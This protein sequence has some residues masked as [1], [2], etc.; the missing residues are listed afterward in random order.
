MSGG[1]LYI[2]SAEDTAWKICSTAGK[3]AGNYL[4]HESKCGVTY[5][6]E[7]TAYEDRT[8]HVQKMAPNTLMGYLVYILN[9]DLFEKERT[10]KNRQER[11]QQL[12][13]ISNIMA[14]QSR[15]YR[16][17]LRKRGSIEDYSQKR[18]RYNQQLRALASAY[19]DYYTSK[20]AN[21]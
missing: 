18:R 4:L 6:R 7:D 8:Y 2:I 10:E 16:Q 1:E 19:S 3:E 21:I 11:E 5:Q 14:I 9:H 13:E 12:A 17:N 20:A 15:N